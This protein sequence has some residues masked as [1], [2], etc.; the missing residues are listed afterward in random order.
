MKALPAI[1]V[2]LLGLASLGFGVAGLMT[3]EPPFGALGILGAIGGYLAA[4]IITLRIVSS[5]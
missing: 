1:V 5:S 3:N 2:I 4:A